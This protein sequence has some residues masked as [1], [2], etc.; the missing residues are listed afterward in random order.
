MSRLKRVADKGAR[1]VLRWLRALRGDL[2]T[3]RADPLPSVS[4]THL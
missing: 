4:Y 2:L 1:T 3:V